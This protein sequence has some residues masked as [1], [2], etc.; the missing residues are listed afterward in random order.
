MRPTNY[1]DPPTFALTDEI[2]I[3]NHLLQEADIVT[4][5]TYKFSLKNVAFEGFVA[6]DQIDNNPLKM[7]IEE[8]G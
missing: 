6:E 8:E 3:I 4:F 2:A 1:P 7:Q 5:L